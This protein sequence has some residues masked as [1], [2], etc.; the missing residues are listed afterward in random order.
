MII[1][2]LI[3]IN[4]KNYL[5][6]YSDFGYFIERDGIQYEDAIDSIDSNYSYIELIDK[7]ENISNEEFIKLIEE[8]L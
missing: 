1:T 3:T 5:H 8:I 6:T 7:N 4:N 2:E